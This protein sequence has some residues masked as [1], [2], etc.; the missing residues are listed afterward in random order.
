MPSTVLADVISGLEMLDANKVCFFVQGAFIPETMGDLE[1]MTKRLAAL[2]HCK[3]INVNS[4]SEIGRGKG[5]VAREGIGWTTQQKLDFL[6]E[7]ARIKEYRRSFI[8]YSQL[9]NEWFPLKL[10][11][12]DGMIHDC[13][14]GRMYLRLKSNG[15]ICPCNANRRIELCELRDQ[16]ISAIWHGPWFESIRQRGLVCPVRQGMAA[17]SGELLK[18][19]TEYGLVS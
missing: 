17:D 12:D 7:I 2:Q 14:A 10:P 11:T 16:T 4:I 8:N 1:S 9:V 19:A 6:E 18:S 13:K 3:G 5:L 15:M